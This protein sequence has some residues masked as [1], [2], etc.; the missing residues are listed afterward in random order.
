MRATERLLDVIAEQTVEVVGA[1]DF[2]A[3][4]SEQA[5]RMALALD[6]I[7]TAVVELRRR[8]DTLVRMHDLRLIVAAARRG[9]D[10]VPLGDT[11]YDT[12]GAALARLESTLSGTYPGTSAPEPPQG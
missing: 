5:G 1:V 2:Q 3:L 4:S 8:G 12:L 9:R 6:A 7:E 11:E 10:H